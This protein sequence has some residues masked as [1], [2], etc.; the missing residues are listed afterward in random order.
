MVVKIPA[1]SGKVYVTFS[2]P[3]SI[4]ASTFHVVGDFNNWNA[5]ATPL[6][7]N[8]SD[9]SVSLVLDA[10][11]VYHYRYLVDGRWFNDWSAD[12]YAPNEHGGDNSVVVTAPPYEWESSGSRGEVALAH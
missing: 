12:D 2:M 1:T 3:A 10:G 8:G 9:W 5:S 7:R 4:G 6:Y 11:R